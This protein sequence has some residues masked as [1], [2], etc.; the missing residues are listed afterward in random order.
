MWFGERRDEERAMR[1]VEIPGRVAEPF[2]RRFIKQMN[3]YHRKERKQIAKV[4]K[5]ERWTN[6]QGQEVWPWWFQVDITGGK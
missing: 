3:R 2:P 4:L 1:K 6:E 5:Q